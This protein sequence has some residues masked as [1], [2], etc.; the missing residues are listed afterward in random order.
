MDRTAPLPDLASMAAVFDR[1]RADPPAVHVITSPVAAERTA[2]TLLALGIRPSLT[3]NPGEVAAFVAATD[4]LLINLGM[5]DSMRDMAITVATA[6]AMRLNRPWVLDPVF[7][8]VSPSRR[9]RTRDLLAL[10]PAVLKANG[11]EAALADDAPAGTLRIITGSQDQLML[12]AHRLIV[13]NGHPLAGR[14]TAIGCALGA[15]I[16]ACLARCDEPLTAAAAAVTAYGIAIE[17]AAARSAG[18]GSFSTAL[19]DC[20]AALDGDTILRKGRIA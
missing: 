7:A 12:G 2:N 8:E 4:A 14:V 18:P 16:A 6:E 19:Y 13:G 3:V 1:L 9:Q 5:L 10:G 17:Q 15:V 11:R 20:L